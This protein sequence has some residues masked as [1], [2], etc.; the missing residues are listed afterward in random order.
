MKPY[1]RDKKVKGN[2][3]WK[4]DYHPKKGYINWWEDIYDFLSRGRMK[5]L[6]NKEIEAEIKQ[7]KHPFPRCKTCVDKNKIVNQCKYCVLINEF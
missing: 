3:S 7:S 1:G 4:K 6:V 5:Q 2:G